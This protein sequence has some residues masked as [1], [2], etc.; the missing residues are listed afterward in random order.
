MSTQRPCT[1]DDP[2][3]TAGKP[4]P[5]AYYTRFP[6]FLQEGIQSLCVRTLRGAEFET[7]SRDMFPADAGRRGRFLHRA[8]QVCPPPPEV[9]SAG[10][11]EKG[12]TRKHPGLSF[13]ILEPVFI[14][15]GCWMDED[16]S[17]QTRRFSAVILTDCK[18]N[19]RIMTG[20]RLDRQRSTVVNT[21]S[22]TLTTGSWARLL[23]ISSSVGTK[24]CISPLWN[25][26]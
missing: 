26:S 3:S 5:H 19:R 13:L 6:P 2:L 24:F 17:R 25:R 9:P 23:A 11:H 14:T 22:Y 12:E 18:G 8:Q 7:R 1:S 21:G 16:F 4:A 10:T 20:K 15:E